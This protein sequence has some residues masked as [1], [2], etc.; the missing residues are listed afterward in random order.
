MLTIRSVQMDAIAE[1]LSQ[2]FVESLIGHVREHF[3]EWSEVTD[4]EVHKFVSGVVLQ[5]GHYRLRSRADIGRFLN[6]CLMFGEHWQENEKT[7]WLHDFMTHPCSDNP[8]QRLAQLSIKALYRLESDVQTDRTAKI[9][10][11][12]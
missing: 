4:D 8:S 12:C 1:A 9:T 11:T 10:R 5:A 7:R 2:K 3:P 6:L